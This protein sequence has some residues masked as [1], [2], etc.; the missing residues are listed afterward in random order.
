MT[1]KEKF[2]PDTSEVEQN[3]EA[4]L[5]T[6]IDANR[7]P[8]QGYQVLANKQERRGKKVPP[9]D[10]NYAIIWSDVINIE[11]ENTVRDFLRRHLSGQVLI[12]LGGGSSAM[13]NLASE[14]G[15]STYVN[16]DRAPYDEKENPNPF[17]P[18]GHWRVGDT[19]N[20]HVH[21]DM[22]EF[23]SMVRENTVN[24]IING[25]DTIIV[26][27][28]KYH[29]ALAREMIRVTKKGGL[30]FGTTSYALDQINSWIEK[31]QLGLKPVRFGEKDG[32]QMDED[33]FIFEKAE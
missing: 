5:R 18:A 30:I 7:I 23:V 13:S 14:F 21:A 3:P 10:A 15:C 28:I 22:L 27:D 24:C 8:S 17:V 11:N 25:I 2:T 6:I 20:L 1:E 32:F 19:M 26:D 9:S 29:E 12:D 16:V 31:Q 33:T 4:V